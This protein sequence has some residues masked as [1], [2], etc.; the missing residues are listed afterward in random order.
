MTATDAPKTRKVPVRPWVVLLVD[1]EPDI[2]ASLADVIEHGLPGVRVLRAVSG[3]EGLAL[4]RDERV[5]AI[6][7]DFKMS[8][9]DGLEF[10]YLA[11]QRH[12]TIPRVMLTAH[13]QDL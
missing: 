4:L 9:M 10:L 12:P 5:D 8:G 1:D 6:L 2:L 11:R 13:A 3:R 7:S